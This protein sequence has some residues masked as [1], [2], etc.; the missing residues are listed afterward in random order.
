[1]FDSNLFDYLL[2]TLVCNFDN[3][4]HPKNMNCTFSPQG[5]S[6]MAHALDTSEFSED[7]D[8]TT[9]VDKIEYH[10]YKSNERC[11]EHQYDI[12][13][14][15][16]VMA[17][18]FSDLSEQ[19]AN[20][21]K[22]NIA[23]TQTL[24]TELA[25]LSEHQSLFDKLLG[26]IQKSMCEKLE[27]FSES[28]LHKL[29][30]LS[31]EITSL[32]YSPSAPK[33]E[34]E[35]QTDFVTSTSETG[36]LSPSHTPEANPSI[37]SAAN[38]ASKICD[39]S[40]RVLSVSKTTHFSI[41]P[42][43]S[44]NFSDNIISGD[45][46]VIT[47]VGLSGEEDAED[48]YSF[49]SA[50]A[51]PPSSPVHPSFTVPQPFPEVPTQYPTPCP[52][53]SS[54]LYNTPVW[55]SGQQVTVSGGAEP[56]PKVGAP[57]SQTSQIA[58]DHVTKRELLEVVKLAIN[59]VSNVTSKSDG[60]DSSRLNNF[61]ETFE[62]CQNFSGQCESCSGYNTFPGQQFF[63]APKRKFRTKVFSNPKFSK[64]PGGNRGN[65]GYSNQECYSDMFPYNPGPPY[66]Y[67]SPSPVHFLDYPGTQQPQTIWNTA[68]R[69]R[70]FSF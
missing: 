66:F 32:K 10:Q 34:E 1:M 33:I 8:L 41:S 51:I 59:C 5:L 24:E 58:E 69:P 20:A 11:T 19:M 28:F 70:K 37:P 62:P 44:T 56:V 45:D 35:T 30:C 49:V 48:T 40:D 61:V 36:M 26:K 42:G 12:Q 54:S 25:S 4:N 68:Y 39:I 53:G 15:I 13:Q 67:S 65:Q 23:K 9:R 27:E 6:P 46:L 57:F 2:I 55:L 29:R 47:E 31:D 3:S 14:R 16:D 22:T 21:F 43:L 7:A 63:S 64:I 50:P 17:A 18:N 38:S 60:V 52:S